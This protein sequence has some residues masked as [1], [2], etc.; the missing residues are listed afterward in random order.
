MLFC[1]YYVPG[2][3]PFI[4]FSQQPYKTGTRHNF[5][6]EAVVHSKLKYPKAMKPKGLTQVKPKVHVL[7][8]DA[9]WLKNNCLPFLKSNIREQRH[10]IPSFGLSREI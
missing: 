2:K 5:P 6:W 7:N 1:A 4:S 8:A 10:S 9:I 3:V